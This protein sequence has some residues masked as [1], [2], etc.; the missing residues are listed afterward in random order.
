[1]EQA[2][3]YRDPGGVPWLRGRRLIAERRQRM[4]KARVAAGLVA[5]WLLLACAAG[6]AWAAPTV[7]QMLTFHPKQESVP[8][9]T[10]TAD[11]IASC[12]V[13]LAKGPNKKGSGWILRGPQGQILRRF[14]DSND[15]NKIDVWSYYDKE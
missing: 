11:E 12:K 8:C 10:P 15:D 3:P 7:A 14:F 13:E 6:P 4:A 9:Y 1:M 5:G 2:R